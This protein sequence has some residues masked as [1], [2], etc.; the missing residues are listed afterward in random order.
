MHYRS[1]WPLWPAVDIE[2][3]H[4]WAM[5]FQCWAMVA[6]SGPALAQCWADVSVSLSVPVSLYTCQPCRREPV[7]PGQI[8]MS[9]CYTHMC[10]MDTNMAPPLPPPPPIMLIII[11][12]IQKKEWQSA[13]PFSYWPV[14]I[15]S[16]ILWN[17]WPRPPLFSPSWLI[18]CQWT[19]GEGSYITLF[20]PSDV[21]VFHRMKYG[22]GGVI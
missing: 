16:Y 10:C 12:I 9:L 22:G 13:F 7:S 18:Q 15:E 5:L 6:A 17:S 21:T 8:V 19:M 11:I 3:R 1:F 14:L 4:V 2:T 20:S